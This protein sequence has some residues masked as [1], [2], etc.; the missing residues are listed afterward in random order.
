MDRTNLNMLQI[1]AAGLSELKDQVEFPFGA[2]SQ[3]PEET[4]TTGHK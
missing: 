1:I 2:F 4:S 3:A